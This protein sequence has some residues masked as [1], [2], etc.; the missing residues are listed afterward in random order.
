MLASNAM[1]EA[2]SSLFLPVA[3]GGMAIG[4]AQANRLLQQ[5][6]IA[7]RGE[8]EPSVRSIAVPAGENKP[9]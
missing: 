1:L 5:A 4:D 6:I 8:K 2:M 7:A 9:P 3:F